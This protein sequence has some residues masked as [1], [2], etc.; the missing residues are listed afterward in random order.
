MITTTCPRRR[1]GGELCQKQLLARG[2][3]EGVRHGCLLI[4]FLMQG[5]FDE[6][7]V[8][9]KRRRVAEVA[10]AAAFYRLLAQ[11]IALIK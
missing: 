4:F 2:K 6:T 9:V 1:L 7:Q 8:D 10:S 3:A 5:A 11:R